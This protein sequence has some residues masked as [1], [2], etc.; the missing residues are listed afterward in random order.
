MTSQCLISVPSDNKPAVHWEPDRRSGWPGSTCPLRPWSL[1]TPERFPCSPAAADDPAET[2]HSETPAVNHECVCVRV[3]VCVCVCV[4]EWLCARVC[5]CVCV[6]VCVWVCVWKRVC[7]CVCVWVC[8]CERECVCVCVCVCVC[9]RECVCVCE[10]ES[11]C[12]CVRE[13]VCVSEWV[14]ECVCVCVSEWVS[15]WVCVCVCHLCDL[16]SL[17]EFLL[18]GDGH[19]LNEFLR[20]LEFLLQLRRLQRLTTQC[21]KYYY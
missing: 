4:C 7:V 17:S 6:C 12:V 21:N 10:R 11:V 5:V 16:L 2:N 13:R 14:R 9:E 8:V 3:C 15:E 19:L 1:T 20:L 18:P